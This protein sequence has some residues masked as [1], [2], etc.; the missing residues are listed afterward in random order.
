MS[1]ITKA[2]AVALGT[3]AMVVSGAGL[4]AANAD[5]DGAALGSPG[6]VSGN[7]I[8][9]P[10]HAPINICNNT[11]HVVGFFNPSIGNICKNIDK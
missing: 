1:L 3:S 4:A 5:A 6:V 9:V 7:V 8:Q 2:G 10:I 11:V